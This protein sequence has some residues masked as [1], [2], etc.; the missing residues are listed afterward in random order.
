VAVALPALLQLQR[1]RRAWVTAALLL[2]CL[3][4]DGG[5]TVRVTAPVRGY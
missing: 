1:A 5:Q 2:L 4:A 3:A